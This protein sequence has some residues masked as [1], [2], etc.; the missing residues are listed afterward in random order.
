[1]ASGSLARLAAVSEATYGTTPATPGFRTLRY[2]SGGPQF[3]KDIFESA[4]LRGDGQKAAVRHGAKKVAGE[5]PIEISY[6]SHD[7]EL[8]ALLGGTW[9]NDVLKAG[10]TRRAFTLEQYFADMDA[11]AKSYMRAEGWEWSKYSLK[12]PTNGMVTGSLGGIGRNIALSATAVTGATYAAP[13]VTPPFDAFTG[14]ITDGTNP[15]AL[16]TEFNVDIE[17]PMDPR[18]VWNSPLTLRPSV[19][20]FK[21]TGSLGAWFDTTTLFEAFIDEEEWEIEVQLVDK[22]G[23]ALTVNLPALTFTS[24]SPNVGGAGAVPI[25]LDFEAYYD[26]TAASNIVLTRNPV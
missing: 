13:L 5:V 1:M 3:S 18:F 16:V 12:A 15:I 26:A 20:A 14:T 25:A 17:R 8:E 4:E 10:T 9:T 21:I 7:V 22:L 24:G 23:N 2:L 11:G 19:G 6:G